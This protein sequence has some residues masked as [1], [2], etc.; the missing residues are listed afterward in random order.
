LTGNSTYFYHNRNEF[1]DYN[2][3]MLLERKH[4]SHV[5]LLIIFFACESEVRTSDRPQKQIRVIMES[6]HDPIK[7]A[8]GK[9]YSPEIA[10]NSF[11]TKSLFNRDGILLSNE[12]FDVRGNSVD[13]EVYQYDE[14][15][16][17]VEI[18]TY[19]LIN[20]SGK[21]V[22]KF[23]AMNRLIEW[24]E[25]DAY[26]NHTGKQTT[27]LDEDG[28]K[29]ETMYSVIKDRLHKKSEYHYNSLGQNVENDYFLNSMVMRKETNRFDQLGNKVEHIQYNL[30]RSEERITHFKY[31]SLNNVIESVMLNG[32]LLIESKVLATYDDKHN[33]LRQFTYGISGNLKEY[34]R[35]RYEYDEV[36]NWT[37]DI[38]FI[39]GSPVSVRIRKIEYY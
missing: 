7:D 26:G 2:L 11:V 21:R 33:V 25:F 35:H 38:T 19:H 23:D 37:K 34:V 36:G 31:D 14:K 8:D 39:D 1:I 9:G 5:C 18:V 15:N 3:T 20:V 24:N 28:N 29:I 17:L 6:T 4:L 32:N 16:N 12:Q 10:E 13:K 22:N 27:R 30:A